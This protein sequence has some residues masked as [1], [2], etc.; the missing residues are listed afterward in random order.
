MVNVMDDQANAAA[1]H[2]RYMTDN[3]LR[4]W[5]QQVTSDAAAA[6]YAYVDEK[7]AQLRSFF[8]NNDEDNPGLLAM[9]IADT[10][11]RTAEQIDVKIK[12]IP[13]GPVGPEGHLRP[14]KPF[15][16]DTVHYKGD[17]V[18]YAGACYQAVRDTARPPPHA[19]DWVCLAA[20][21]RDGADARW[22]RVCGTFST[23]RNYEQ[24]DIVVLNGSAFIARCDDPGICPSDKWQMICAHGKPGMKGPPGERGERGPRG[25]PGPSIVDWKLDPTVYMATPILSDGSEAQALQLR[26]FFQQFHDEC[27]G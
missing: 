6:A 20:A 7:I 9:L 23:S 13:A 19:D 24:F 21:G 16:S 15:I 2:G 27:G 14:V 10:D 18:S 12:Q 26:P 8:L 25:E 1:E 22:P 4:A 11:R 17:C 5:R 3:E